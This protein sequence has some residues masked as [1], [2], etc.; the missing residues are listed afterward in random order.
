[1]GPQPG[2]P[3]TVS[4][5]GMDEP[6]DDAPE[7]SRGTG[8][9]SVVERIVRAHLPGFN[10]AFED[11][12]GGRFLPGY[13]QAEFQSLLKCGDPQFGFTRLRC[14]SSKADTIL[15]FSCKGR[16]FCPSC[17]GRQMTQVAAHL[18]A[19][20]V[21]GVPV[22][23]WVLSVPRPLRLAL[24]MDADLCGDVT[25]AHLRAVSASYV[26]RARE[27]QPVVVGS[28]SGDSDSEGASLDAC[29]NADVRF[30]PGAVNATQRFG[31]SLELNVHQHS[32]F[33]DGA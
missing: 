9:R 29:P 16:T 14:P 21:P 27:V 32:L 5:D 8:G 2:T 19:C 12:H 33:L 22:R 3:R 1:M 28:H 31:S 13:V 26:G 18:E 23:Q 10:R 6:Q 11:E 15:P 4:S 20:V 25:R 7:F 24:A 30:H 17:G